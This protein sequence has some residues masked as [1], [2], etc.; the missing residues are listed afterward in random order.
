MKLFTTILSIDDCQHEYQVCTVEDS[1]L[2]LF[3]PINISEDC[4]PLIFYAKKIGNSWDVLNITNS[5][6]KKQALHEIE[7][8]RL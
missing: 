6:I 2:L 3:K 7:M 1:D 8:H 4:E 5:H